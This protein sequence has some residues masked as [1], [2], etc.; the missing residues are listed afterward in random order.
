MKSK[1]AA[2]K[3]WEQMVAEYGCIVTREPN[4]QIHHVA[5]RSA[6]HN[7]IDIGWYYILP[8]T[9]RLHDVSSNHPMNV[10]LWK[11]R[12]EKEYGTQNDLFFQMLNALMEQ[13][14]EIPVPDEVIDA[15][16]GMELPW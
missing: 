5:G 3:R 6:R 2:A 11:N 7:K 8:L 12:F 9:P 15:I 10:T 14:K 13:G 16:A 1:P 4:V